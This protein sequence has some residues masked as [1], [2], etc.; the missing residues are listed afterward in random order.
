MNL[1]ENTLLIGLLMLLSAFFSISE[2]SLAAA[3]KLK[4]EQLRD[5]GDARAAQVLALQSQPGHFFTAIQ[6]G[7]NTVAILAG[8]LGE[9]AYAPAFSEQFN[10]IV[11]SSSLT[12][13]AFY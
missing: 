4:L 3:R 13:T 10:N 5:D 7:L 2:I 8:V 11:M 12:H 6:I 9:G 1:F